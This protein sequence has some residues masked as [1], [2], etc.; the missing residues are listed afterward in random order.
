MYLE[1][2]LHCLLAALKPDARLNLSPEDQFFTAF[3]PKILF[4]K[5][6]IKVCLYWRQVRKGEMTAE[7]AWKSMPKNA[8]RFHTIWEKAQRHELEPCPRKNKD[9]NQSFEH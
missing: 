4:P 7:E 8:L 1:M 9:G 3:Y 2:Q 5:T 6:R